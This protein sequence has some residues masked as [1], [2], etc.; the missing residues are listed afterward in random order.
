MLFVSPA[1]GLVG[2]PV[3]IGAAGFVATSGCAGDLMAGVVGEVDL[4]GA[5]AL[6]AGDLGAAAAFEA[7]VDLVG[8]GAG[9]GAGA[10]AAE[11]GDLVVGAGL[12]FGLLVSSFFEF[13][14]SAASGCGLGDFESF[15]SLDFGFASAAA[16]AF[17]VAAGG[18]G[19]DAGAGA[20]DPP[21]NNH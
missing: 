8:G 14:E 20:V 9:A 11:A 15:L 16:A 19:G 7:G 13:F 21:P 17:F 12:V 1:S 18:G 3:V 6:G 4:L 2:C 5:D 10:G